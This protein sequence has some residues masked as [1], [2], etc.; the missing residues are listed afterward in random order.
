MKK[1]LIIL[2]LLPNIV[3]AQKQGTFDLN[4]GAGILST[5]HIINILVDFTT[6]GVDNSHTTF[7]TPAINTTLKYAIKD[8]WFV[9]A[10]GIYELEEEELLDKND[11]MIGHR[12]HSYY[13]VGIGSEYHYLNKNFIQLYSGGVIGGTLTKINTKGDIDNYYG[14]NFQLNVIGLRIG[15]KLAATL[16]LGVGYKGIVNAGLSYQF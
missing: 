13:S 12:T 4:V 7:S 11:A 1:L 10:E 15:K 3:Q 9:N 8:N 14:F 6:L 2:M 5:N 16:E